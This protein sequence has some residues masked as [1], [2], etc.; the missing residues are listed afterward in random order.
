MPRISQARR[1]MASITED[2][3]EQGRRDALEALKREL[4]NGGL[5]LKWLIEYDLPN[6][7]RRILFYKMLKKYMK[8]GL[9]AIRSTKS[10]IITTSK[11]EAEIVAGLIA[12]YGG[13]YKVWI[14]IQPN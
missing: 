11:I 14:A 7:N 12:N 6:D 5:T 10:V 3:I 9:G 8:E 13:K 4:R 1:V 2:L